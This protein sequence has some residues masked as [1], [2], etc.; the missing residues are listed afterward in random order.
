MPPADLWTWTADDS[1]K[2]VAISAAWKDSLK[3]HFD[4]DPAL[5]EP[6][7]FMPDTTWK[8]LHRALRDNRFKPRIFPAS[9]NR[10]FTVHEIADSFI[11]TKDTTVTVKLREQ[12]EGT[13][14]IRSCSATLFLKDTLINN[15]PYRVYTDS[16][17]PYDTTYTVPFSGIAERYLFIEPVDKANR[18]E[19]RLKCISGAGRYASPDE[20]TAPYLG[21]LQLTTRAGRRDTFVLRPDSLHRGLQ[22]LYLR[23]SLL[24]YTTNDSITLVLNNTAL[25][26]HY[27]WDPVDIVAYVYLPNDSVP[28]AAFEKHVRRNIR[29]VPLSTT[30]F[31]FHTPGL[32]Q[33]YVELV[34]RQVL[35]ENVTNFNSR[36]WAIPLEITSP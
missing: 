7:N 19:W 32:K 4:D 5:S 18:T 35:S 16:F 27:W 2:V 33:I 21:S 6:S 17:A 10:V 31:K 34:P 30:T 11:P 23:E 3:S 24:T 9:F 28:G 22:R 15:L 20:A 8:L 29:P 13:V 25:L 1:V 26:G 12:I 14:T 36:I